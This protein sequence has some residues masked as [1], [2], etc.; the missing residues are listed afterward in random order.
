M[1]CTILFYLNYAYFSFSKTKANNAG[2]PVLVTSAGL[3]AA[4]GSQ[5]GTG[6]PFKNDLNRRPRVRFHRQRMDR[7]TEP[8][9]GEI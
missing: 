7:V 4:V 6:S 2:L 8:G 3:R 1:N 5:E 9:V